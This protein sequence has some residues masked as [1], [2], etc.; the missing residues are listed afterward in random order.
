MR[1]FERVIL[2]V[3]AAAFCGQV[4]GADTGTYTIQDYKVTLTPKSDGTVEAEYYQKW[5]VTGGYIPWITVG[6]PNAN[7]SIVP[8]SNTGAASSVS[9]D[10]YGNW[11]GVRIQL[12]K[13]YVQGQTFEAGFK[14]VQRG[15][16]YAE[17]ENYK[18]LFWPGWYDRA[19]TE[20]L[21]ISVFL[22]AKPETVKATPEPR[23]EGQ[24][25]KWQT[26]NIAPGQKYTISVS[27]PKRLMTV[28]IR[29]RNQKETRDIIVFFVM[30][31]IVVFGLFILAFSNRSG[32]GGGPS[33]YYGGG[34]GSGGRGRGGKGGG[35]IGTGGGGGFGGR[36]V[37]C[38]CA[39]A[40][41]GCA[42]AC[43]CAGGGGA[44]CDRKLSQMCRLC[45]DCQQ[46]NSCTV[47][48][49]A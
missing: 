18:M 6:T 21:E 46:R 25:L 3:I 20:H 24:W 32:Y 16:F 31:S 43:A 47:W 15:L 45:K 39:C 10:S 8:Q 17:G 23:R 49:A 7:F 5:L 34:R 26:D 37:S 48:K 13:S 29:S 19:K 4:F 12:D 36:S 11:S 41:A 33:I 27:I 9:S 28:K 44:G 2:A 40:C 1:I 35:G 38:V 22:F 42:C 14:I 30:A